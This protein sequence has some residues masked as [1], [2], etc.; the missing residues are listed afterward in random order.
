MSLKSTWETFHLFWAVLG[1]LA[2]DPEGPDRPWHLCAVLLWTEDYGEEPW[3]WEEILWSKW[4]LSIFSFRLLHWKQRENTKFCSA[5][6]NSL[7]SDKGAS[8]KIPSPFNCFN[9]MFQLCLVCR[10][11]KATQGTPVRDD[12]QCRFNSAP[13]VTAEQQLLC[14]IIYNNY[15]IAKK[16]IKRVRIPGDWC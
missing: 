7:L 10:W 6:Q 15:N 1:A 8:E 13:V 3:N 16:K 5:T 11:G 4:V 2:E 14:R 9:W 12:G